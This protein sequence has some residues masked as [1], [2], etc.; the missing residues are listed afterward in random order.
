MEDHLSDNARQPMSIGHL[1]GLLDLGVTRAGHRTERVAVQKAQRGEERRLHGPFRY[2]WAE[3]DFHPRWRGDGADVPI[4]HR[5]TACGPCDGSQRPAMGYDDGHGLCSMPAVRSTFSA[6]ASTRD[7]CTRQ[8]EGP[9]TICRRPWAY[10]DKTMRGEHG[11][12][13]TVPE[14]QG[15]DPR[16]RIS[17][18]LR[19]NWVSVRSQWTDLIGSSIVLLGDMQASCCWAIWIRRRSPARGARAVLRSA[20]APRRTPRGSF[21]SAMPPFRRPPS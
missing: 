2:G 8:K 3:Y 6:T 4:V 17:V 19:R 18:T 20:G 16:E 15:H 14:G 5:Q 13:V 9:A 12:G 11:L 7:S 1:P 10:A 21:G